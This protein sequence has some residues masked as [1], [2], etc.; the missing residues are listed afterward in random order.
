MRTLL[1]VVAV[2][3]ATSLAW[4][5]ETM[6]T[7][8]FRDLYAQRVAAAVPGA[9]ITPLESLSL[10][11]TLPGGGDAQEM[12]INLDRAY[13]E[14]SV[15]PDQLDTIL[16]RWVRIASVLPLDAQLPERIVSV[17]R[18]ADHVAGY[19]QALSQD[20]R[21]VR[22]VWRPLAG[23]LVEMIA[24]DSPDA[25]QFGTE[26]TLADMS[27]TPEQA[28]V[29]APQNLPA[30]LGVLSQETLAPGLVWIGGGNGLAPSVLANAQW[31][32]A[33]EHAN[34]LYLVVDR[35]SFL[36]AERPGGVD[37]ITLVRNGMVGDGSAFSA[38]LL[39]CENGRLQALPN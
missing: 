36:M 25:I 18:T 12:T 22:L 5:Q 23:D 10:R 8:Q 3:F 11:I 19:A 26:E 9:T 37:A 39:A 34:A 20:G 28:W 16:G 27:I 6:S 38:T 4:A 32:A 35:D 17:V 2:L 31:C 21:E 13:S 30:R 7:V 24:F 14:Y 15:A 29:L 33:P 1:T